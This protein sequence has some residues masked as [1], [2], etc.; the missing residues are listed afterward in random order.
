MDNTQPQPN[1]FKKYKFVNPDSGEITWV[2]P[3]RWVWAVRYKA[4]QKDIEEAQ[5]LTYERNK[6]LQSEIIEL[7]KEYDA[8]PEG[9]KAARE[10]LDR[11]IRSKKTLKKVPLKPIQKELHQFDPSGTFHRIGEVNQEAV[12]LF[13]IY[14]FGEPQKTMVVKVEPTMRLIYKYVNAKPFFLNSFIR[15][16]MFGYKKGSQQHLNFI[17]PNDIVVQSTQ[18]AI[19]FVDLTLPD[20]EELAKLLYDKDI[21]PD[22]PAHPHEKEG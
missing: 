3:E 15:I 10:H 17:L 8:T 18:H 12:D 6:S 13:T 11:L 22:S 5:R 4:T 1:S 2:D 9:D 20:E 7:A 16:F 21:T 14:K 19:D